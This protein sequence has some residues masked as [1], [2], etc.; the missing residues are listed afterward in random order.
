MVCYT[1][2]CC[3][4]SQQVA[5]ESTF[6][7]IPCTDVVSWNAAKNAE[8]RQNESN[9]EDHRNW[10]KRSELRDMSAQKL[11]RRICRVDVLEASFTCTCSIIRAKFPYLVDSMETGTRIGHQFQKFRGRFLDSSPCITSMRLDPHIMPKWRVPAHQS[12]KYRKIFKSE[13]NMIIQVFSTLIGKCQNMRWLGE[14]VDAQT[15]C[16]S[17]V[18]DEAGYSCRTRSW[19][20]TR[21]SRGEL[22]HF[23]HFQGQELQKEKKRY[24][25]S[26]IN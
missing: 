6:R 24:N 14:G 22:P 12:T 8:R 18:S 15:V 19:T 20:W 9:L 26:G 17:L 4:R 13:L 23:P 2:L 25:Q 1:N 11:L 7:D 16:I 3:L 5:R 10:G 21:P